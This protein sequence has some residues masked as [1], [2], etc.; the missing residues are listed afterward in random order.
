MDEFVDLVNAASSIFGGNKMDEDAN[1]DLESITLPREYLLPIFRNG[2]NL[3]GIISLIFLL[4]FRASVA[5]T[6]D[7]IVCGNGQKASLLGMR[8]TLPRKKRHAKISGT[9][10]DVCGS[11][12]RQNCA[13]TDGKITD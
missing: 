11:N 6:S 10:A 8:T 5:T 9:H 13:N 1:S 2:K 7:V 12:C 3:S 4:E